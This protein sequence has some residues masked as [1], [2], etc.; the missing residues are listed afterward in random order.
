DAWPEH[1]NEEIDCAIALSLLE[2]SQWGRKVVEDVVS[3]LPI[4]PVNSPGVQ[5]QVGFELERSF[6]GKT[7]KLV[8]SVSSLLLKLSQLR[9]ILLGL[10]CSAC[11]AY[12]LLNQQLSIRTFWGRVVCF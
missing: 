12:Q 9:W 6:E 3:P 7:A 10:S 1:E 5:K 2:E 11:S 4:D 8:E